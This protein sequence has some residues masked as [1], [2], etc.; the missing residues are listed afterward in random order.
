MVLNEFLPVRRYAIVGCG[1]T[2]NELWA[3]IRVSLTR[4]YC[5]RVALLMI[6]QLPKIVAKFERDHPIRDC[7]MQLGKFEN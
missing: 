6:I 2:K 4:R 5:V 3:C 7:Q 1:Q